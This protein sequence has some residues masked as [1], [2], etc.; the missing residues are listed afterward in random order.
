[1]P[2]DISDFPRQRVA[3]AIAHERLVRDASFL[4]VNENIAGFEVRQ[5]TVRHL[6]ILQ[7]SNSP[8]LSAR[9]PSPSELV[10]FLW[11]LNPSYHPNNGAGKRR[12]FRRCSGLV[13]R[14]APFFN[15]GLRKSM[16]HRANAQTLELAAQVI[17]AARAYVVES[18]Q[19]RPPRRQSAGARADYYSDACWYCAE[20][21]SEF[22]WSENS[23]IEMPIKRVF[24]YVNW[25]R[26]HSDPKAILCNPSQKITAE[27]LAKKNA[28]QKK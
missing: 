23:I 27:W 14:P 16:W 2:V 9:T 6:V 18:F 24:Q 21:A 5:L 7:L 3:D 26:Q 10:Q 11:L 4:C 8:F 19:D 22:S 15:F 13:P 25:I 12:F 20:L 17:D 28:E 1:M